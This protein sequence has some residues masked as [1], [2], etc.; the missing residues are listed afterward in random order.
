MG[1]GETPSAPAG[2]QWRGRVSPLTDSQESHGTSRP[3]CAVGSSGQRATS[4]PSAVLR[5]CPALGHSR[6]HVPAAPD[7]ASEGRGG[8]RERVRGRHPGQGPLSHRPVLHPGE[9]RGLQL[10][11]PLALPWSTVCAEGVQ[12]ARAVEGGA[13]CPRPSEAGSQLRLG[14]GGREGH[15]ASRCGSRGRGRG[16]SLGVG[17]GDPGRASSP[18]GASVEDWV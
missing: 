14:L 17:R 13:L 15:A 1:T 4:W 12:E 10:P 18:L 5:R 7:G 2:Q 6:G 8:R 3:V 9:A 11:R 16:L